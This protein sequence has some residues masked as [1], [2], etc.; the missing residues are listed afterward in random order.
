M[1]K[2]KIC[3]EKFRPNN[4]TA[5]H[6]T[7]HRKR[8]IHTTLYCCSKFLFSSSSFSS[9]VKLG[10]FI[11]NSK[12]PASIVMRYSRAILYVRKQ[13]QKAILNG[14]LNTVNFGLKTAE[15]CVLV[16]FICISM[17]QNAKFSIATKLVVQT[18]KH[19][20]QFCSSKANDD[21]ITL[22]FN[23]YQISCDSKRN[24][25]EFILV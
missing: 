15:Q 18:V 5:L 20:Y 25:I 7:S 11:F 2:H 10:D 4:S 23:S 22:N 13:Q 24:G 19:F 14:H 9:S 1:A 21:E 16:A 12:S 8:R 17:C 6:G 3:I